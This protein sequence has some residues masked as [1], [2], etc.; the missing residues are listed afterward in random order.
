MTE[1]SN[2]GS[3]EMVSFR[4]G[5]QDF[6]VDI[7]AVR[8]IRGW[9]PA[10]PLPQTPPYVK[11]VINLR[12]TV[13]PIIDLSARMGLGDTQPEARNVIVVAHV[14][15]KIVGLLVDA[16]SDILNVTDD[17]IQPA[18]DVGCD[19]VR[20]FVRGIVTHDDGM[21]SVISLDGLLPEMQDLAAA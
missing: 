12:G 1:L 13:L 21:V 5:K 10:T 6:C 16:V 20:S 2:D 17:A 4:A 8:E 3:R 7:S 9:A 18:P 11:G 15:A 14:G 19:A